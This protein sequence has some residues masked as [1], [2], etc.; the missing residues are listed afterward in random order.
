MSVKAGRSNFLYY[1]DRAELPPFTGVGTFGTPAW[2]VIDRVGDVD[3]SSTKNTTEIDLRSS[4]TTVVVMGNK[5]REVSFT[6]YKR[7]GVSDLVFNVLQ[8]SFENNTP[9]DIGLSEIVITYPLAFYDRGSF[10]V[11]ELAKSEPIAGV[12]A[13]EVTLLAADVFAYIY[14]QEVPSFTIDDDSTTSDSSSL[15]ADTG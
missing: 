13:Y 12:D 2:V 10:V 1:N 4:P 15:T 8:Y 7:Q 11:A 14:G 6:Y 3:R 9:L 5:A